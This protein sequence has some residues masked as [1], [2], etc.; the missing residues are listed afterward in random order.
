MASVGLQNDPQKYRF[1]RSNEGSIFGV[2]TGLSQAFSIDLVTMRIIWIIALLWF[3]CGLPLYLA[4]AICLPRVDQLDQ[5][6]NSKLLGVCARISDKYAV[7]V[8]LVR[9][10]FLAL[11]VLSAGFGGVLLYIVLHFVIPKIQASAGR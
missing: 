10:G 4:L 2:C 7:E 1:V 8:G 9:L 6:L 3:G 11:T 5:A